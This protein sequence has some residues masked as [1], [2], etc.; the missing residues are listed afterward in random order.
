MVFPDIRGIVTAD[1]DL[2]HAC[3]QKSRRMTATGEARNTAG[4][5]FFPALPLITTSRRS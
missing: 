2:A 3:A 5:D 1:L 4:L